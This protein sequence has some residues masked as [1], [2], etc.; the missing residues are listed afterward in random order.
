MSNESARYISK[1]KAIAAIVVS[2]VIGIS[3]FSFGTYQ[4]LTAPPASSNNTQEHLPSITSC[5]I[6]PASAYKNTTLTVTPSGWSDPNGYSPLYLITWYR[7]GKAIPNQV[8]NTL[9]AAFFNKTDHISAQVIPFDG[10]YAGT[11]MNASEITIEDS[12][13]RIMSLAINPSNPNRQSQVGVNIYSWYDIDGDSMTVT[14]RWFKNGHKVVISNTSAWLFLPSIGASIGDQINV[15]LT[16]FDGSVHGS[17][18]NS[19][20][21]KVQS[22]FPWGYYAPEYNDSDVFV[23]PNGTDVASYGTQTQPFKT[24]SY[25]IEEAQVNGKTDVIVATGTYNETIE[26]V[27]GINILGGYSSDFNLCSEQ[28]LRAVVRN[29]SQRWTINGSGITTPTRLDGLII[30][31]PPETSAGTDSYGIYL[32]DCDS[33]LLISNCT[34]LGGG[35]G[36][37]A[38]G[39]TGQ[40][41][42]SG[43]A[44][45]FGINVTAYAGTNSNAGGACGRL[46]GLGGEKLD[47]GNGSTT[48]WGPQFAPQAPGLT[49]AGGGA[50]GGAG[51][52]NYWYDSG[53]TITLPTGWIDGKTGTN[54]GQGTNGFQGPRGGSAS[55]IITSKEWHAYAGSNGGNGTNGYGGGGGGAGGCQVNQTGLGQLGG[56]GGGGGSGGAAGT[57]GGGG[58]GGGGAFCIFLYFTSSATSLPIIQG[59]MLYLGRGGCGGS[60][61]IGGTGGLG[62]AGGGGGRNPY[63]KTPL[64][65]VGKGGNGGIGGEGGAGGGGGG[66]CGGCSCG[67]FTVNAVSPSYGTSNSIITTTGQAGTGGHGGY[68]T[69]NAGQAG[70][71]GFLQATHYI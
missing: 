34:V 26:L 41:G 23:A 2:L 43:N 61:G 67:I 27:N 58:G 64:M 20:A 69:G 40:N 22:L 46:T 4:F 11:A 54:G 39:T 50:C 48:I 16:P 59:N 25:G 71:D 3:G 68:S 57:C 51:G 10:K 65:I 44:G 45:A 6:T 12:A 9:S 62:G 55:G 14:Y 15:E 35:A 1:K 30:Y 33:H 17:A 66:G 42:A 8:G 47:G 60:G 21:V 28:E 52:Y 49:A 19:S 5:T 18:I 24:I 53:G 31:G 56:S 63:T 38:G 70:F 13:P 37:G 29:G 7:N 32:E 36:S